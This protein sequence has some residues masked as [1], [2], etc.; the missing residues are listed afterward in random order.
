[1]KLWLLLTM[2]YKEFYFVVL[3][4]TVFTL[5][6]FGWHE[7]FQF[8]KNGYQ[9]FKILRYYDEFVEMWKFI[10]WLLLKAHISLQH[11]TK[12]NEYFWEN[13]HTRNFERLFVAFKIVV[14]RNGLAYL[15]N[16]CH[17]TW[18]RAVM[19]QWLEILF[20]LSFSDYLLYDFLAVVKL[21]KPFP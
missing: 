21:W 2:V 8:I 9:N 15:Q 6:G 3:L 14:T 11:L 13:G 5:S 12:F 7:K 20:K 4:F 1:M 18:F 16:K 17:D 19:T 10:G